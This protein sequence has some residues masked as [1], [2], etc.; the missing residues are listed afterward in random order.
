M[1]LIAGLPAWLLVI[2]G[3]LLLA[4]AV[5]D[6]IRLRISNYTSLGIFVAAIVAMALHGFP[7]VLWQNALVFA[8]LLIV[9]TIV[10]ASGNIGGGDVKLLAVVG[11]WFDLTTSLWLLATVL[12]AGGLLAIAAITSRLVL[13]RPRPATQ[14]RGK[15]GGQIAYGLAITAGA[16]TMLFLTY[17]PPA[18]HFTPL[19]LPKRVARH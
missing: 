18:P 1:N 12:V 11:L 16:A 5:E 7:L 6:A 14:G 15:R 4:A 8:A 13:R 19:N 2:L 3:A 10:F 9:G 17:E